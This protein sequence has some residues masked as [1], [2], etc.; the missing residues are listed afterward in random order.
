MV[1]RARPMSWSETAIVVGTTK[2][3]PDVP[4]DSA[5]HFA[6]HTAQGLVLPG[7]QNG[8]STTGTYRDTGKKLERS[9]RHPPYHMRSRLFNFSCD[10]FTTTDSGHSHAQISYQSSRL[11]VSNQGYINPNTI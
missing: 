8:Y 3:G 9:G 11:S 7:Q 1:D 6:S 5:I 10:V 2:R 4:S